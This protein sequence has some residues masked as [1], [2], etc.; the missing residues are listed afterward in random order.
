MSTWLVVIISCAFAHVLLSVI[1]Y[2]NNFSSAT[3]MR[4]ELL[5]EE[6]WAAEL[7]TSWEDPYDMRWRW[8]LP[9]NW[10][11]ERMFPCTVRTYNKYGTHKV[12]LDGDES[13]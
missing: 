13:Q 4:M 5:T 11:L 9:W 10:S 8:L 2:V 7:S 6:E 1:A 3:E 12:T